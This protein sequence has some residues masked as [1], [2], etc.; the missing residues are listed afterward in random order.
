MKNLLLNR[1]KITLIVTIFAFVT[2][3]LMA[4]FANTRTTDSPKMKLQ[5]TETCAYPYLGKEVEMGAEK[6]IYIK[7]YYD[8]NNVLLH[9]DIVRL[10][11]DFVLQK[12]Y[13]DGKVEKFNEP[14]LSKEVIEKFNEKYDPK[15]I[16][17]R[18]KDSQE[19]A[20]EKAKEVAQKA[21]A[22]TTVSKD[23]SSNNTNNNV[24]QNANTSK[25]TGSKG[26]ST[27]VSK[28]STP[29]N[30]IQTTPAKNT[31][32]TPTNPPQPKPETPTKPQIVSN[33]T[34]RTASPSKDLIGY[35]VS[36]TFG[37]VN[38]TNVTEKPLGDVNSQI[39]AIREILKK[40]NVPV[41]LVVTFMPYSCSEQSNGYFYHRRYEN[42]YEIL[43]FNNGNSYVSQFNEQ[44]SQYKSE[45]E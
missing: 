44:F 24:N 33:F 40:N 10:A 4:T 14:S 11:D 2:I 30:T 37:D 26:S 20:M 38:Y 3:T 7:Y 21:N 17:D 39:S 16:I 45:I 18:E 43:L 25:N 31:S 27:V 1:K 36:E 12:M 5:G 29:T 9:T 22:A 42:T 34:I 13:P 23:T 6:T 35:F 15:K 8:A 28:P 32:T 19:Q 41:N